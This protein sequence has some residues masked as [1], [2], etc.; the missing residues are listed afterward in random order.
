M[1]A[2]LIFTKIRET[3]SILNNNISCSNE[4][5]TFKINY[6]KSEIINITNINKIH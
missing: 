6:K 2:L 4:N 1:Q 5:N 3:R